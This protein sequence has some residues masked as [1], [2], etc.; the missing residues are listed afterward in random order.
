MKSLR[1]ILFL[2]LVLIFFGLT[3]LYPWFSLNFQKGTA[4]FLGFLVIT[5][6]RFVSGVGFIFNLPNLSNELQKLELQVHALEAEK[7]KFQGLEKE[8]DLLKA[9]LNL[10]TSKRS[11]ARVL[12]RV[13]GRDEKNDLLIVGAG[14]NEALSENQ[15][16]TVGGILVGR[17][18]TV[19]LAQ[20]KIRLSLSPQSHFVVRS[21]NFL[22]RGEVSGSFGNRLKL[23]QVLPSQRLLPGDLFLEPIHSL[24]VGKV[25]KVLAPGAQIFKEAELAAAYDPSLLFEVFILVD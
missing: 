12:A 21:A 15:L 7:A 13:I 20:S 2:N 9:E 23:S 18:E 3:P 4:P 19:G 24:L 14:R 25:E 8:N 11:A 6:S 10:P 1:T 5:N 17:V 16:V 22:T